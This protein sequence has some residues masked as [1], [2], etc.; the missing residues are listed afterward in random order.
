MMAELAW[1]LTFG[2]MLLIM[3]PVLIEAWNKCHQEN[4]Q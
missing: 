1:L 2:V 3:S 4:E